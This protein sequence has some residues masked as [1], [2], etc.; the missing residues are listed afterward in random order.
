MTHLM[1]PMIVCGID[2]LGEGLDQF[3]DTIREFLVPISQL[4]DTQT[5]DAVTVIEERRVWCLL[6]VHQ[7]LAPEPP[8]QYRYES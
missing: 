4:T 8:I 3:G 5:L 6:L 7:K 2:R 1:G